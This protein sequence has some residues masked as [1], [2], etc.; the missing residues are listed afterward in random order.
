MF[1]S[2]KVAY[3]PFYKAARLHSAY[4]YS[5]CYHGGKLHILHFTGLQVCL[6]PLLQSCKTAYSSCY[7]PAR[8]S[9][10]FRMLPGCKAPYSPCYKA[11]RL[12]I[13]HV[14]KLQSCIFLMLQGCISL[15]YEAPRLR[16]PHVTELQGCTFPKLK[17]SRAASARIL[18]V[19]KLQSCIVLI[20]PVTRLQGN[21]YSS[22]F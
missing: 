21:I 16:I 6:V 15:C 1:Q 10:V 8:P 7:K 13:P 11:P 19:K 2:C 22:C 17:G 18:R 5:S 12:H 9:T 14:S 4:S 3:L 20:P